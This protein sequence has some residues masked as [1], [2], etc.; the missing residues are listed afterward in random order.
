MC[1][2]KTL[3]NQP[4]TKLFSE[5]EQNENGFA[6]SLKPKTLHTLDGLH[7]PD[8]KSKVSME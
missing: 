3:L 2:L 1:K 6:F 7:I 4:T 5:W 8:E